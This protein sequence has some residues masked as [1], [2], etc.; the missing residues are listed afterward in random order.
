[1]VV[2][3]GCWGRK[4][5][6]LIVLTLVLISSLLVA[7]TV[8]LVLLLRKLPLI[9]LLVLALMLV[10]LRVHYK[11]RLNFRGPKTH[12][13]KPKPTKIDNFRRQADENSRR[14]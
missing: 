2:L 3:V 11:K 4:A 12:E 6:C 1:L 13:N 7:L 10:T 9:L 5:S 8:L 14:K